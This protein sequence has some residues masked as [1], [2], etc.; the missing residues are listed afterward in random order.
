MRCLTTSSSDIACVRSHRFSLYHS[1]ILL[2]WT[3]SFFQFFLYT[4]LN[5][6]SHF[7]FT[8]LSNIIFFDHS[9]MSTMIR[10][11]KIEALNLGQNRVQLQLLII[12]KNS[13]FDA[14]LKPCR[15]GWIL[16]SMAWISTHD[17]LEEAHK[18]KFYLSLSGANISQLRKGQCVL[19]QGLLVWADSPSCERLL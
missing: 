13:T 8:L 6:F 3:A 9:K 1:S 16:Q 5:N 17:P 11:N 2:P 14:T 19:C 7:F 10:K 4:N 18:T 15:A 12:A